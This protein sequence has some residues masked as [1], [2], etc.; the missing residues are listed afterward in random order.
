MKKIKKPSL[1]AVLILPPFPYR[2]DEIYYK[3]PIIREFRLSAHPPLGILSLASCLRNKKPSF[4][5]GILDG[6]ILSLREIF[7][8][9]KELKPRVVGLS[10]L[11]YTYQNAIEI[12]RFSKS[13]G[14]EVILGGQ[15]ATG[16]AGEILENRGLYSRDY[17]IDAVIQQDGE[18]ALRAVIEGRPLDRVPN[19]I[20]RRRSGIK[21]NPVKLLDLNV[22][23]RIDFDLIDLERY[24]SGIKETGFPRVLPW[25]SR[26]GCSWRTGKNSGCLFCSLMDRKLRFRDPGIFARDL[27]HIQER[28]QPKYIWEI[29]DD[30]LDNPSWIDQYLKAVAGR[31]L[32]SFIIYTRTDRIT[33]ENFLRLQKLGVKMIIF[34]FESANAALL[35][36]MNKP[37]S[38]QNNRQAMEIL[39][40]SGI[41]V[42][43]S[44][45]IGNLGETAATLEE[46][47][48]FA[49]ETKRK[50]PDVYFV[51]HFLKPWPN[52]HARRLLLGKTGAK[53]RGKD[54]LNLDE[55][56]FD[57]FKYFTGISYKFAF[58]IYRELILM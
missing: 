14:A 31:K 23:P 12:A 50:D 54:I 16:L 36:K 4:R 17:C 32:P 49:K 45:V 53:Y 56:V 19:A 39:R 52:S 46:T 34:G 37:G 24:W 2:P 20:Y 10:P 13:L 18:E 42:V 1:D 48:K 30:F 26:K 3:N 15:H 25:Y 51:P 43:N 47:L 33:K 29:S 8:V 41:K 40:G 5:V 35:K 7:K 11:S 6:Q 21:F 44:V 27:M 57:W 55:M 9:I 58:K 22:L 28:F 38:Q